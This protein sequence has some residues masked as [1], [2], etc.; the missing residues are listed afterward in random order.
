M[1]QTWVNVVDTA[2]KIGLGA[3]ISLLSGYLI[4]IKTQSYDEYKENK[5]RFYKLIEEK[6][7][8]YVEFLAQSQKL[9]QSHLF[10]SASPEEDEYSTYLQAF[11]AIQIIVNDDF[12]ALAF[13]VMSDVS[14]FIFLRKNDQEDLIIQ[15]LLNS[16]REKIAIFQKHAQIDVSRS[17]KPE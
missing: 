9:L 4:L 10:S 13:G 2:V 1:E 8:K 3:T 5:Q 12:R 14:S 17:Y 16:A 6:K 15:G 7:L 11:N